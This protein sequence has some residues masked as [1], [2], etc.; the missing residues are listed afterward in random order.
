MKILLSPAKSLDEQSVYPDLSYT[1]PQFLKKT[2]QL[3]RILKSWNVK[4]F[5]RIMKLSDT[6]AELNY[7][8][9]QNWTSP[10]KASRYR[11]PAIFSFTG[12]VY[13]GLN[14]STLSEEH[15][16]TLNKT[17]CI[18]SGLYGILR[19]FDWMFPYRL[20]M[21][22]KTDFNGN[23]NLYDFWEKSI[24]QHLN[25]V[26]KDLIFNLA[27]EEYFKAARLK[28]AKARVITPVFKDY[29]NG[30]LTTIM[31]YAKHQRGQFAR[32]IIENPDLS[33]EEYKLYKED[34]YIYQEEL[35]SENEWCFV[36]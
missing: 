22:T 7:E 10:D 28:E 6:L 8:R 20:E 23:K 9:Y 19:P 26:E 13:K 36:R 34:G 2:N 4:D 14:I 3:A 27:S 1:T 25:K 18:L 29:K 12:E 15:Y 31:M 32:F 33:T 35:S 24:I 11:R 21:G 16:T 30:K 5:S 17:V